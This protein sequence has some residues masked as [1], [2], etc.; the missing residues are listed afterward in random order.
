MNE[1]Q[2]ATE[3]FQTFDF[4][5]RMML[6]SHWPRFLELQAAMLSGCTD[7]D[8]NVLQNV[9]KHAAKTVL[10][11]NRWRAMINNEAVA[12]MSAKPTGQQEAP[13]EPLGCCTGAHPEDPPRPIRATGDPAP[14]ASLPH[15]ESSESSLQDS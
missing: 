1:K 15:D 10:F 12:E 14:A 5:Q 11:E 6:L 8:E 2:T 7:P 3:L 4:G 9:A 13:I